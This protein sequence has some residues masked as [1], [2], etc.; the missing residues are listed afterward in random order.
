MRSIQSHRIILRGPHPPL[1]GRVHPFLGSSSVP[2]R[3]RIG[4]G[5]PLPPI[6]RATPG[7]P[8]YP[9]CAACRIVLAERIARGPARSQRSVASATVPAR[10]DTST[11]MQ[12][13][14]PSAW[15]SRTPGRRHR[16]HRMTVLERETS[17]PTGNLVK[18]SDIIDAPPVDAP[19]SPSCL[20]M[21]WPRRKFVALVT[22]SGGPPSRDRAS[23][24]AERA[25]RDSQTDVRA[26]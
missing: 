23:R 10:E 6:I 21:E 15:L 7:G 16:G 4:P 26:A 13:R 11:W 22:R 9:W 25:S 14:S 20:E 12:T 2:L 3:V 8:A 24:G 1:R 5:R 17:D 19:G 18:S